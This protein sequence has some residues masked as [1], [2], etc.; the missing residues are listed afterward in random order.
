MYLNFN[1]SFFALKHFSPVYL[2]L[3]NRL[4]FDLPRGQC[5]FKVCK[6]SATKYVHTLYYSNVNFH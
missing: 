2:L 3:R 1:T 6:S 4:P 5:L